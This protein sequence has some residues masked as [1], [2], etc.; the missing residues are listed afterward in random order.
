MDKAKCAEIHVVFSN[1]PATSTRHIG[2][3]NKDFFEEKPILPSDCFPRS[4][5]LHTMTRKLSRL[6]TS[7][8]R[9]QSPYYGSRPR[10]R[11]RTFQ[12]EK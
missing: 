10:W 1:L 12:T 4:L 9:H 2:Y 6:E 7:L 11:G 8:F 3:Q 5:E